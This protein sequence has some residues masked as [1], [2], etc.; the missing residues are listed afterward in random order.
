MIRI[1]TYRVEDPK[2]YVSNVYF[3]EIPEIKNDIFP[4]VTLTSK[5]IRMLVPSCTDPSETIT[6]DIQ[7]NEIVKM[8]F[9][10]S[11]SLKVLFLYNFKKCSDYVREALDMKPKPPTGSI[12]SELTLY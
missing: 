5:G 11:P 7:L 12:E 2:G 6:L 9:H 1:G 8:I 10:F 3:L 4:Q